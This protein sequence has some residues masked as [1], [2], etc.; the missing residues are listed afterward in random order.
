[1][2]SQLVQVAQITWSRQRRVV[3]AEGACELVLGQAPEALLGQSLHRVLGLSEAK[4]KELDEKA[5]AA[6]P[7]EIEFIVPQREERVFRL[8]LGRR[9]QNASAAVTNLRLLLTGA[10]PVQIWGLASSVSHEIGN[11]L[12]SVKMAVQTLARNTSLSERDQRRL[13]IANREVRTIE[14]ILWLLSEYGRSAAPTAESI[15]LLALVHQATSLIEP[16]LAEHR[17]LIQIEDQAPLALV[18]VEAGRVQRVI[19]QLLLDVAM[20]MPPRSA[21]P[22]TLRHGRHEGFELTV[23][24]SRVDRESASTNGAPEHPGLPRGANL[25]MAALQRV[26]EAHGGKVELGD[27][28]GGAGKLYTLSFPG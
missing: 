26:M 5:M 23:L 10:P 28:S 16:E 18:R 22:V 13:A 25:S 20:G 17:T 3:E 24:D 9:N 1:V 11:P 4:A 8:V 6:N 21:L 7:V 2:D 14:R 15:A 12:S 27:W 19:A